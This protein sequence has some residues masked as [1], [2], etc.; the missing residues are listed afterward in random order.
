MVREGVEY[1]LR[2]GV[3]PG[4]LRYFDGGAGRTYVLARQASASLSVPDRG[5]MRR[6]QLAPF[7]GCKGMCR[8]DRGAGVPALQ[9]R[10]VADPRNR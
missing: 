6:A 5:A 2:L 8:R 4:D 3:G 1:A 9:E 7:P 10:T